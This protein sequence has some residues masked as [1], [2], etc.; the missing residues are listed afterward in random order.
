MLML[1]LGD[2]ELDALIDSDKL[3]L[4]EG[5]R[6]GLNDKETLGESEIDKL[7]LLLGL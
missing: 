2:C 3:I 6:L 7:S 5:E 4:K 1:L